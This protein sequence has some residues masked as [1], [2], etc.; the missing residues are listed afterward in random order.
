MQLKPSV[1][2]NKNAENTMQ[3]TEMVFAKPANLVDN[4]EAKAASSSS[5]SEQSEESSDSSSSESSSESE[6]SE[7]EK[8]NPSTSKQKISIPTGLTKTKRQAV[9][10]MINER[11]LHRRFDDATNDL[12]DKDD[13]MSSGDIVADENC[14]IDE[15]PFAPEAENSSGLEAQVLF[16]EIRLYDDQVWPHPKMS[17]GAKRRQRREKLEMARMALLEKLD[18]NSHVEDVEL[19][20]DI[21]ASPN[22]VKNMLLAESKGSGS[23]RKEPL[24]ESEAQHTPITKKL[25]MGGIINHERQIGNS[26]PSNMPPFLGKPVIGMHIAFKVMEMSDSYTPEISGFKVL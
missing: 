7:D 20:N 18:D 21:N 2:S 26:D 19:D 5:E 25:Y 1:Q 17:A 11:G 15:L 12:S 22:N 14:Y 10:R 4:D 13:P 6:S 8:P 9:G 16:T 24:A 3:D 23:K